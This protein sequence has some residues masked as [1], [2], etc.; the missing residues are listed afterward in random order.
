[1]EEFEVPILLSGQRVVVRWD[2]A[3][4]ATTGA[5]SQSFGT[6]SIDC[7]FSDAA[8]APNGSGDNAIAPLDV[9]YLL[10]DDDADAVWDSVRELVASDF[11]SVS[12]SGFDW[13][14]ALT[15]WE[16][17]GIFRDDEPFSGDAAKQLGILLGEIIPAVEAEFA[18]K[19]I[20]R[21][22]AGYSLAGLFA[23]WSL[24]QTDAFACAASASGSLWYPGFVEYVQGNAFAGSPEHAY[25]SLGGKESRTPSRLLRN[26]EDNT[27]EIVR[28][29]KA[30]GV[31]TV[32][33]MNP[34]N[35]FKDTELRMAKAIVTCLR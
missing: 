15:P 33:E 32:F 35:H 1:M 7:D 26:V 20:R 16:C 30:R 31:E 14:S 2:R 29:F 13:N 23:V 25:F 3:C 6:S 22:I 21:T 28:I 19:T 11:V 8:D 12:I 17:P 10:T 9:V 18:G 5:S 4:S 34:G 24:F 27:R